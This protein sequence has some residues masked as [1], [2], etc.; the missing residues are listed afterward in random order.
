MFIR[1]LTSWLEHFNRESEYKSIAL[2]VYIILPSLLLQKPTRNSK[3]KDLTKKLEEQLST[4]KGGRIMDLV[5]EGRIIQERIRS[6]CQQV[7]KDYAKIFANLMMQG[8]V[9]S[10]LK[11]LTSDPRV[12]VHKISGDFINALKQKHPKLS[13]IL[14]NALLNGLVNEVLPCYFDNIDEEMVSKASSLTK[15]AS[16]PSQLDA[17]QYHHLLSSCKYKV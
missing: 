7:S 14:E 1:E 10:A 5:K 3:V 6:S 12:G 4:W 16:G 8:R 17:M 13:P 11:I 15:G 2:K 9:S